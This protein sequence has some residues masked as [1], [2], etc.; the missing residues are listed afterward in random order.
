MAAEVGRTAGFLA[1]GIAGAV[2][3]TRE[4]VLR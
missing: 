3:P 4:I 2:K 1:Y